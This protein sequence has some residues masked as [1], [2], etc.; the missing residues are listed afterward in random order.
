MN[1]SQV[2]TI[3][4]RLVEAHGPTAEAEAARKLQEAKDTGDDAQMQLWR[5]VRSAIKESKPA[6][7]S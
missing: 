2:H 6:H 3:A 4:K 7:E 1:M 5:R